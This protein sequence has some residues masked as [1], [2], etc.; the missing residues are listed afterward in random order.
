MTAGIG[1]EAVTAT[2]T[3]GQPLTGR[4]AGRSAEDLWT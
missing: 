2:T 3:G 4:E 1:K